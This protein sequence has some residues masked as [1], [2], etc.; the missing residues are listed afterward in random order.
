MPEPRTGPRLSAYYA[1][2][3]FLVGIYMPYWPVFLEGRGAD[4]VLVGAL[5]ALSPWARAFLGPVAGAMADRRSPGGMLVAASAL[6]GI[7]FAGFLPDLGL[8][9]LV[10]ISLVAS[11]VFAPVVPLADGL[12]LREQRAGRLDYGRARLWGSLG[13]IVATVAG[14]RLLQGAPSDRVLL[15][16]LAAA[17]ALALTSLLLPRAPPP[18]AVPAP[19]RPSTPAPW[20]AGIREVLGTPGFVR[21]LLAIAFL[22]ASHAV[23]YG[24][25]TLY[26]QSIEIPE[27]TI[28]L[29]WAEGVVVEVALFAVGAQVARRL[30][31]RG[32]LVVAGFGG[33]VRWTILALATTV[34]WM[35]VAQ[36]C[37]AM[38]FASLHLGAM[39][40]VATS[41]S[42]ER[43]TSATTLYSAV[44][45]GLS[46]GIGMPIAGALYGSF[47]GAAFWMATAC[48]AVGLGI[49]L[50]LR[51]APR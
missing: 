35:A 3:F 22:H 31:A 2:L 1:A 48:A 10:G 44:G 47:G 21:F 38:T 36:L 7:A 42:D 16:I 40:H 34:P 23:L 5:L 19:P 27:T 15:V 17:G 43:T 30:G 33:L 49:A 11:I 51:R 28:G 20:H 39:T 8:V 26:W 37:H 24:F 45:G 41:V 25:G 9:H 4:A 50:S 13:F 6:L 46:M 12:A 29:L 18:P 32:L 14:G